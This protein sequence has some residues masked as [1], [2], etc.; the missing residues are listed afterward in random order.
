VSHGDAGRG[1]KSGTRRGSVV[2]RL[3]SRRAWTTGRGWG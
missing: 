1:F 2:E 3:P